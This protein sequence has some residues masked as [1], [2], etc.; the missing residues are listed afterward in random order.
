M[1]RRE[2]VEAEIKQAKEDQGNYI[3]DLWEV[4]RDCAYSLASD[5]DARDRIITELL[6]MLKPGE[7]PCDCISEI[8]PRCYCMNQGDAT[9]VEAWWTTMCH[10]RRAC[11]I[12]GRTE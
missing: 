8:G 3:Y 2:E 12:A 9:K 11:K 10:Y 7:P 5:I 6:A 4:T 1:S